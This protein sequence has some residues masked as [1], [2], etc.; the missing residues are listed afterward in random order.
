MPATPYCSPTAQTE[1]EHGER[2][3]CGERGAAVPDLEVGAA[4][5]IWMTPSPSTMMTNRPSR[6]DRWASSVRAPSM[7]SSSR[8][9]RRP[10]GRRRIL[11][12]RSWASRSVCS[13]ELVRRVIRSIAM[14]APHS[15]Y[16][17][18]ASTHRET[19]HGSAPNPCWASGQ[20]S[21]HLPAL[22]DA[23]G[24]PAQEQV[25]EHERRARATPWI[26]GTDAAMT[27]RPTMADEQ[28]R[29]P[30]VVA[31]D[32]AVDRE[33]RPRDPEGEEEHRVEAERATVPVLVQQVRQ[34]ADAG[35]DDQVEEQLF[36]RRVP[37]GAAGG[38]LV[39]GG[40]GR[41]VRRCHGASMARRRRAVREPWAAQTRVLF[42]QV[43]WTGDRLSCSVPLDRSPG[44]RGGVSIPP[45]TTGPEVERAATRA[46]D[47]H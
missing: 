11:S 37:L 7:K 10:A 31:R 26:P 34:L 8:P 30:G 41:L 18:G 47:E 24:E 3:E 15:Q 36:P 12:S 38:G 14:P 6:S 40:L 1:G 44:L 17:A 35:D 22:P 33:P 5:M 29:R 20:S 16:V 42:A 25:R 2:A 39:A 43:F 46:A 28:D 23:S 45:R 13:A 9:G 21:T 27:A 32:V 19:S 4:S